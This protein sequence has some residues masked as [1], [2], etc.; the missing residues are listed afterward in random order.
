MS[1][2]AASP[3]LPLTRWRGLAYRAHDPRWAF[4]PTSGEGA[5]IHGGRFNPKGVKA[6]YLALSIEGMFAE[7]SHGFARRFPP[8]TVVTYDVD[9]ADILDLTTE[10][11]RQA[12]G[13]DLSTLG[14][15][16]MLD[17]AEGRVPPSWTLTKR[18]IAAGAAGALVPSFA[19]GA[20]AGM[21]N[22]VLW[23]WGGETQRVV[24]WDQEGRLAQVSTDI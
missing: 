16:W 6:L 15:A 18:L 14:C 12:A 1:P 17:R 9:C 5:A 19:V 20:T 8:L 10:A 4:A 3:D 13:T 22:L 7:L 21:R 23:R 2:P 11:G 24:A